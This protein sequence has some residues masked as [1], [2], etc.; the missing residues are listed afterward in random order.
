M[1]EKVEGL[2]FLEPGLGE[3]VRGI[4]GLLE[5]LP[6]T[7]PI[8]G[9]DFAAVCGCLR[10]LG[11]IPGTSAPAPD[12]PEAELEQGEPADSAERQPPLPFPE[13]PRRAPSPVPSQ[14]F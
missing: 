1:L 12:P 7:G 10:L 3:M 9:A 6:A 8:K 11:D 14:W 2:V 13:P 4:R 5:A